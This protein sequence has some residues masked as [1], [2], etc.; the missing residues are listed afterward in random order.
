MVDSFKRLIVWIVV[1]LAYCP[2]AVSAS[3]LEQDRDSVHMFRDVFLS[4][5]EEQ[6]DPKAFDEAKDYLIYL[7]PDE[8]LKEPDVSSEQFFGTLLETYKKVRPEHL[9]ALGRETPFV[10]KIEE[11][12]DSLESTPIT[13]IFVPGIYGE[14]FSEFIGVRPFENILSQ[15]AKSK[16]HKR[17]RA[18]FSRSPLQDSHFLIDRMTLDNKQAASS[19]VALTRLVEVSSID[20][21]DKPAVRYVVLNTP[22]WSFESMGKI[23]STA[24][25]F[26]RRLSKFFKIMDDLQNVVLVGFSR[27]TAIALEM[28]SQAEHHK[29]PWRSKIK[30][31]VTLGGTTYGGLLGDEI[32]RKGSPVR[33][34]YE[35]IA[36][37]L[38]DGLREASGNRAKFLAGIKNTSTFVR[39]H[40]RT[41]N[42]LSSIRSQEL[43]QWVKESRRANLSPFGDLIKE[44]RDKFLS[45]P[46]RDFNLNVRKLKRF[47]SAFAWS[48]YELSTSQRMEWWKNNTLPSHIR[49]Y[50]IAATMAGKGTV[51]NGVSLAEN[52][53]A[54]SFPSIDF[55]S[56]QSWYQ[57]AV[58]ASQAMLNDGQVYLHQA[59]FWPKFSSQLNKENTFL[60]QQSR[61][62][63]VLGTSHTAMALPR[64]LNKTD[65]PFPR[66]ALLKAIA[67]FVAMDLTIRRER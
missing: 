37:D 3:A 58:D 28:L 10:S 11:V 54:Y 62:L 49:Y 9:F 60:Q 30:A 16:F 53:F 34:W 64:I 29:L 22:K 13:I 26:N 19:E 27:G 36:D 56:F 38:Y 14:L 44:A 55:L 33:S 57:L 43:L 45:N 35:A 15:S 66:K 20:T 47:L 52:K 67:A 23:G 61:F 7:P 63:G 39:A 1:G 51:V 48:I 46:I 31:M 5:V 12:N 8:L 4:C 59:R 17:W 40:R 42:A 32:A 21:Q 2:S 25:V 41:M 18:E 50:A 65:N 24:K 6:M